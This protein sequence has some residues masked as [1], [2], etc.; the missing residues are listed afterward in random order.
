MHCPVS[1]HPYRSICA[2]TEPEKF[3]LLCVSKLY[4]CFACQSA[5]MHD[6]L[7]NCL[8]SDLRF[9]KFGV[10]ATILRLATVAC[11]HIASAARIQAARIHASSGLQ[12]RHNQE[13]IRN[14][15]QPDNTQAPRFPSVL[16]Y[17]ESA[18]DSAGFLQN[19]SRS[20][21]AHMHELGVSVIVMHIAIAH[22]GFA[23][24]QW[25]LLR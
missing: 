16:H 23:C 15:E 7:L 3:P 22:V 18:A 13:Q 14:Q 11:I 21:C 9:S 1:K 4:S 5:V 25:L 8:F 19:Y 2:H 24:C 12:Q 10:E 6:T 20:A 17:D